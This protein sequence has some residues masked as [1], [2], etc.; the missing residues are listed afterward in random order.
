[1]K[2]DSTKETLLST[3]D[4]KEHEENLIFFSSAKVHEELLK[5]NRF[6]YIFL[7]FNWIPNNLVTCKK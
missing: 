6:V 2:I 5:E 4:T 3:K 1:M 7:W